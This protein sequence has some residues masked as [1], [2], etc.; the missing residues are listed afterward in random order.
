ME[1]TP[2]T[3]PAEDQPQEV[4]EDSGAEA[5]TREDDPEQNEHAH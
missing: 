4:V 5:E 2:F 3:E 1:T